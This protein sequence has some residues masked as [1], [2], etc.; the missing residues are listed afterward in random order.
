MVVEYTYY[1]IFDTI[2]QF[3]MAVKRKHPDCDVKLIHCDNSRSRYV[4]YFVVAFKDGF[5]Y[6]AYPAANFNHFTKCEYWK[7]T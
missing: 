5:E 3:K 6:M 2:E 1:C 4:Q 7:N